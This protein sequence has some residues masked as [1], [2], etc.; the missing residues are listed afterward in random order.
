MKMRYGFNGSVVTAARAMALVLAV[1][2]AF[3]VALGS[4]VS[5]QEAAPAND[6][7][8]DAEVLAEPL[9]T[10]RGQLTG[11]T[12]EA[13]ELQCF[14][15]FA[16]QSVWLTF[17]AAASVETRLTETFDGDALALFR[18][19]VEQP[20]VADLELV[21]CSE[22]ARIG[23][24][25]RLDA[26]LIEGQRYWLQILASQAI[27]RCPANSTV[28]RGS[29]ANLHCERTLPSGQSVD[30]IGSP[31]I[32]YSC[33]AGYRS[34]GG[35]VTMRCFSTQTIV[36][37]VPALQEPGSDEFT[38]PLSH[39]N[40]QP[41][42]ICRGIKTLEIAGSSIAEFIDR[43][44][45]CPVESVPTGE[46][47]DLICTITDP[48]GTQIPAKELPGATTY[49]CTEGVL[50]GQTCEITENIPRTVL[51]PCPNGTVEVALPSAGLRCRALVGESVTLDSCGPTQFEVG[52][53]NDGSVEC[54]DTTPQPIGTVTD[55]IVTTVAATSRQAPS[56]FTCPVSHPLQ[57]ANFCE[58]VEVVDRDIEPIVEP[59]PYGCPEDSVDDG[60]AFPN[61]RCTTTKPEIIDVAANVTPSIGA[62]ASYQ[63][64]FST[65]DEPLCT[66]YGATAS[67]GIV[68]GD[69]VLNDANRA[70][71]PNR[72]AAA[73]DYEFDANSENYID[74]CI[75][76]AAAGDYELVAEM[77][78]PDGASDSFWV[79]VNGGEPLPIFVPS[80][81]E[82]VTA[83]LRSSDGV[84]L[85]LALDAGAHDIRFVQREAGAEL[86]KVQLPLV[87]ALGNADDVCGDAP[88][89]R[90]G[91][92]VEAESGLYGGSIV[93]WTSFSGF[94]SIGVPA[95]VP[96]RTVADARDSVGFCFRA[97]ADGAESTRFVLS[98]NVLAPDNSADSF[99]VQIG[100]RD[101][102]IWHITN[103]AEWAER[104]VNA[105]GSSDPYEFEWTG[106]DLEVRLFA[107]DSGTLIDWLKLTPA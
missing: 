84:R 39:P 18:S 17:V 94:E 97:E 62:S 51:Y 25:D 100:E 11:A 26:Q 72:P 9:G 68:S 93:R 73:A 43:A 76:V 19:D 32:V 53:N 44:Y 47:A 21:A 3:A 67:D 90:V 38:C 96:N 58:N 16:P 54:I 36:A 65:P 1:A 34:E 29:G 41:G 8:A 12:V 77:V 66:S 102:F 14:D 28:A 99:W 81:S 70:T 42:G 45:S 49:S 23:P 48:V 13:G 35:G 92:V 50:V 85:A 74:F 104:S 98:A 86:A 106:G 52:V 63:V 6:Q 79:I 2:V 20:T 56:T 46:R 27:Y 37:E 55:T 82:P 69:V 60:A 83:V 89:A 61:K 15:G 22:P 107:R 57:R 91:E 4:P 80:S 30:P 75:E 103:G 78:A 7:L 40:L 88:A 71:T 5:A 59:P 105:A 31:D 95:S 10:V 87:R 33:P 24:N 101:P 64:I